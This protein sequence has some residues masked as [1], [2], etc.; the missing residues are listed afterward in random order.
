LDS[1]GGADFGGDGGFPGGG[2][3][4]G[5]AAFAGKPQGGGRPRGCQRRGYGGPWS[6]WGLWPTTDGAEGAVARSGGDGSAGLRRSRS[7]AICRA[8]SGIVSSPVRV[9]K[10]VSGRASGGRRRGA[11]QIC[12][13]SPRR[14]VARIHMKLTGRHLDCRGFDLV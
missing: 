14:Q 3:F 2:D 13:P 6:R 10:L 5:A 7:S 8:V 9:G 4:G 1:T 12:D 11:L